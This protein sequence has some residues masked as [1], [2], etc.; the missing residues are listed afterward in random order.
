MI[1]CDIKASACDALK[2]YI[3]MEFKRICFTFVFAT[4]HP[5]IH[6]TYMSIVTISHGPFFCCCSEL[7]DGTHVAWLL[8]IIL[9]HSTASFRI[10][11]T[12]TSIVGRVEVTT[13]L[14]K[15]FSMPKDR[16]Q[17]KK[18]F[19]ALFCS[20]HWCIRIVFMSW[21][22]SLWQILTFYW[23]SSNDHWCE[24]V[25]FCHLLHLSVVY[26]HQRLSHAG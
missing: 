3:V 2:T 14:C 17:L 9:H 15:L 10:S 23:F 18:S 20:I 19:F 24:R 6:N 26:V 12:V 25:R 11:V 5:S 22:G 1:E 7:I 8:A 16:F 13:M 4:R 21:V